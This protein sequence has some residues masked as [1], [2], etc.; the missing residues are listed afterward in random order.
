MTNVLIFGGGSKFGIALSKA[1]ADLDS[2]IQIVTSTD[3]KHK[4][5]EVHKVDWLN[6]DSAKTEKLSKEFSNVDIVIFNQNYSQINGLENIALDKIQM[7]KNMKHWKQGQFVNC[8]L[9]LQVCNSLYLK[10]RFNTN[11]KAVWLLSD[12]INISGNVSLEYKIQKYVNHEM[13]NYINKLNILKCIGFN[14]GAL[15]E[16]NASQKAKTLSN[17]LVKQTS[18][19]TENYYEFD[20][21]MVITKGKNFL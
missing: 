3:V 4:N 19:L 9:P 6:L 14:P 13:V 21:D 10:K 1:F 8:E 2:K 17:F 7:M 12:A 20:N 16:S 5:F 11:A 18:D 15:D